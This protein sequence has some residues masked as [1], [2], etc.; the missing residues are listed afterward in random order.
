MGFNSA[1]LPDSFRKCIAKEERAKSPEFATSA[2]LADK[3]AVKSEKAMHVQFEN[4]CRV[5]DLFVIHSRTDR[6]TT[7]RV[8][9][10]DF[11]VIKGTQQDGSPFRTAKV[12]AVEFKFGT[13]KLR[14]EQTEV[15]FDLITK[16]IPALVAY[17]LNTAIAWTK[18]Q[19]GL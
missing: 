2:E 10:P 19:L 9:L 3:C 4:W 15:L 16:C 6:K 17:D 11:F 14:P 1:S 12:C 7:I 18:E 13:G 5:N 8:G